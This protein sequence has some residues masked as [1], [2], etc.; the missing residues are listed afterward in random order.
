LGV[1]GNVQNISGAGT[2]AAVT[3][4]EISPRSL[5]LPD[6]TLGLYLPVRLLA[7]P[8]IAERARPVTTFYRLRY[9]Y[10]LAVPP[11]Q[12]PRLRGVYVVPP[13]AG[14]DA[15]V[16]DLDAGAADSPA[17]SLTPLTDGRRVHYRDD[18]KLRPLFVDGSAETYPVLDPQNPQQPKLQEERLRVSWYATA[19]RFSEDTTG[20]DQPDTVLHLDDRLTTRDGTIHLWAVAIDERGGTDWAHYTLILTR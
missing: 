4:P 3:M 2:S 12:N 5:G 14:L 16:A 6:A 8:P 19:G 13:D 1:D 17:G 9:H 11:N 18:L 15:A 20:G 7:T 10:A